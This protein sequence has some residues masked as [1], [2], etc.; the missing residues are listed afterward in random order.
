MVLISVVYESGY[1]VMI[2]GFLSVFFDC[3]LPYPSL[4]PLPLI[5]LSPYSSLPLPPFAP[6]LIHSSIDPSHP[7]H[8]PFHPSLYPH[9]PLPLPS[10]ISPLPPFTL[11]HFLTNP[12]PYYHSPLPIHLL[13]PTLTFSIPPFPSSYIP[14]SRPFSISHNPYVS[15]SPF[16]L[17]FC[18]SYSVSLVVKSICCLGY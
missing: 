1:L 12:S 5:H 10:Y 8:Y 4:L 9:S 16:V 13:P 3:L 7:L 6:V 2:C 18:C 17:V 14:L 11:P 15:I